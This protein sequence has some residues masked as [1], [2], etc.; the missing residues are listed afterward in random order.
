VVALRADGREEEE[1]ADLV[2]I[3]SNTRM[4]VQVFRL[5]GQRSSCATSSKGAG[6]GGA[7]ASAMLV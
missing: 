1:L 3:S 5:T 2:D 7:A 4:V 6:G